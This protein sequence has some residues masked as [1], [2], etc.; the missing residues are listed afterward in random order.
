MAGAVRQP[1]DVKALEAWIDKNAP[2]I[3]TPVDVKQFGYGQSNPTYLLTSAATSARFVLRKK[4]PGALVSKTAHKVEREHRIIAALGAASPPSGVPVPRT[5]GLCADPS[6][7]GTPFYLM[8]FLD[9]RILEDPAMPGVGPADRA[10]M[11]RDAVR[12]LAR[13]HRVDPDA[14]GLGSFGRK[15]GFYARQVETWRAVCGAQAAARDAETGEPVGPLPHFEE[16][17]VFFGDVEAQP[18]DRATLVHGDYKIDNLVF[19]KTEPR[20]IGILDWEMSTIG[21]PLSDLANFLTPFFTARLHSSSAAPTTNPSAIV[22]TSH[23]GF[24]PGATPGLPTVSEIAS[25]YAAEAGLGSGGGAGGWPHM[26]AELRWTQAFNILRLAAICQGIAA[27]V[28][29]RQAS[30][31]AAKRYADARA[32]LAEFAWVLVGEA[33]AE[34]EKE[35][36]EGRSK[37]RL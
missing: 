19:H 13:L 32:P 15:G 26:E 28:A 10:A 29:A 21:H 6:V 2:E 7:L 14:V 12:T 4:P 34:A 20:V 31:A 24:L 37:A 35:D 22:P 36:K 8:E 9:G 33:R 3:K 30:S 17:M 27:R 1:I 11:W 5:F 16:M 23:P 18:R 25:L